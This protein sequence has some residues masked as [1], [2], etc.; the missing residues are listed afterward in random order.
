M[1]NK[2]SAVFLL[3]NNLAKIFLSDFIVRCFYQIGKTP[4]LPL[5]AASVGAGEF[6]IGIIVSISTVTGMLLKPIFGMLSDRWGRKIWL[7]IA[8]ILFSG[9]P[10]F[11][12]FVGN[13]R[14]LLL[15]RLF[16]GISTAIFGPV[17][18]AYVAGINAQNLGERFGYFGMSRLL[19]SLIAPLIAGILLTFLSFETVFLLIGICSLTA[20]VPIIF[21]IEEKTLTMPKQKTIFGQLYASLTYSLRMATVW[22]AGLLELLVYLVIYAVKAFLPIFIISQDSGTI[23]QAGIFFFFQ[24]GA[25]LV[26]RPFGGKLSD[27]YG[28]NLIIIIGL[29]FLCVGLVSLTY[30]S[31]SFLLLSA[32]LFGIGQ[33]LIF[34]SSVAL[35][36]KNTEKKYLGAAMG[37]YGALR[38]LGKVIGPI[39]AG[40]LLTQFTYSVV[41]KIFAVFILCV[42]IFLILFSARKRI[43]EE[44]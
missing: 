35:L 9:T 20:M 15:L 21:L 18:L 38:N 16:H 13:E 30:V 1:F 28:Q 5:Y 37:F 19:A 29:I 23:F 43:L 25:H 33:G 6:L 31:S 8:V 17:S 32:A 11:Y 24:E 12:Q 40:F 14:E 4:L 27:K 3:K 44:I 41:F 39:L 36:S 10:F 2:S 22:L 34:P 42:V 7:L 26:S